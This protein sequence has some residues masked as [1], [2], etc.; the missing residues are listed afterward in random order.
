MNIGLLVSIKWK[1]ASHCEK[2]EFTILITGI[3]YFPLIYSLSVPPFF[4]RN[5]TAL[6]TESFHMSVT[7]KKCALNWSLGSLHLE[8]IILSLYDKTYGILFLFFTG[9]F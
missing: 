9:I 8:K 5:Y 7:I 6:L 3:I 2:T 1:V 4:E